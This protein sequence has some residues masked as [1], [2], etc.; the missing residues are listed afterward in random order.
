MSG[1]L[2]GDTSRGHAGYPRNREAEIGLALAEVWAWLQAQGL[3]IPAD[4]INGQNGW[5]R[6]SGRAQSMETAEDFTGFRVARLLPREL[7]HPKIA[8]PIWR[9][10]MRGEYDASNLRR[11]SGKF[12]RRML[13][14]RRF[15]LWIAVCKKC[16][17]APS[18]GGLRAGSISPFPSCN[19]T[20]APLLRLRS[21]RHDGSYY[22]DCRYFFSVP[23][24]IAAVVTAE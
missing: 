16:E 22:K 17:N 9:A 21:V 13:V 23:L 1:E 15:S 4:G 11:A 14:S 5:R 20:E 19:S 6:L 12:P 8:I 7:L 24:S 10:F 18:S 3:V 2:W